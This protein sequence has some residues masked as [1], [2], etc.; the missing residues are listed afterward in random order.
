MGAP[1]VTPQEIVEMHRLYAIYGTYS[2]VAYET[3]RH[4]S[5]VARYIKMENVPNNIRLTVQNLLQSA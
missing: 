3:G 4:P 5:T 1:R 2:A